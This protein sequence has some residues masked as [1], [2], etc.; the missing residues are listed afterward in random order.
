MSNGRN[1]ERVFSLIRREK[2]YGLEE[3]NN[4]RVFRMKCKDTQRILT[5]ESE[6]ET[7]IRVNS[8]EIV[9]FHGE[10]WDDRFSVVGLQR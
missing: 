1:N 4:T 5:T 8:D 10:N 2:S 6:R 3:I 7:G 9:L